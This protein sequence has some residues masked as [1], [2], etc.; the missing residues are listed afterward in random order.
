MEMQEMEIVIDNEG[1]ITVKVNGVHGPGCLAMTKGI[2]EAVG[3]VEER[4]CTSEYY[5]QP[6][7]EQQYATLD[8]Y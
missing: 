7:T 4:N 6:V 8:R 3:I 2:E 5:E 1:R